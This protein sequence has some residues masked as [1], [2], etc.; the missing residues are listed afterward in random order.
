MKFFKSAETFFTK[1]SLGF[2]FIISA[3]AT[4][5]SLFFSEILGFLPCKLCWIQR[6]FMYPIAILSGVALYRKDINVKYY[7]LPLAIIGSLFSIYHYFTQLFPAE[8]GS[9]FCAI[10]EASCQT[11]Y[12]FAYGYITIPMMALTAFI[13]IIVF[14]LISKK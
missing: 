12:T 10:G 13:L 2:V 7:I 6:I 5:G 8:T 1:N 11:A 3:T 9:I 4:L 14:S